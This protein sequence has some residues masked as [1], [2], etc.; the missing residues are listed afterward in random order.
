MKKII[1]SLAILSLMFTGC[2]KEEA[3]TLSG[4]SRS[5]FQMEVDGKKTDLYV[6]TNANGL[7]MCVT[8]FGGK[9]VSLMVPDKNGELAD[10]VLGE[11]SIDIYVN[12]PNDLYYGA[13]IGR[14]GNRIGKATFTLDSVQYKLAENNNGNTLHGGLKGFNHVVWDAKQIDNQTLELTYVSPDMEEGYP[15]TLTTKMTYKLTDNDEFYIEYEATTDKATVV[16][17]THHSYF[18]LAG[19]GAP[20]INDHILTLNADNYTPVDDKLIPTGVVESVAGTPMDFRVPTVIGARVNDTTFQQIKFGLG[21]DHN[22]VL[23]KTVQ[24]ELTLAARVSEP[25]S[26]RVMEIF[27]TEPA[28]QFYGGNFMTGK[29]GKGGKVYPYRAAFCLETQHYPDSPNQP[30]FPSTVLRPGE[31]YKHVCVYTFSVEK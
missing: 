16:N 8:N 4:L 29:T 28:I 13:A 25:V 15:G 27:T 23:N 6:L 1:F 12:R 19:A 14:Y 22:W 26:G 10:I 5:A 9:V 30:Q 3:K 21:Y 7:E 18:N 31:T 2:K 24:G 11:D 17:I 20:S